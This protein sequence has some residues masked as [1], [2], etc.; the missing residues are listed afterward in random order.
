MRQGRPNVVVAQLKRD[1]IGN[2]SMATQVVDEHIGVGDDHRQL[3]RAAAHR[4]A[5]SSA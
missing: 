4:N 3:S 5:R 2:R 1:A